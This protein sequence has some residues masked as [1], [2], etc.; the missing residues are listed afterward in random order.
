MDRV[1]DRSD[2]RSTSRIAAARERVSRAKVAIVVAAAVGFFSAVG[3]ERGPAVHRSNQSSQG[4]VSQSQDE[5]DDF[6]GS[7]S[8]TPTQQ[9]PSTST[10]SS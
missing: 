1:N 9:A 4:S 10:G 7:G 5:S 6:F 8:I 3:L 2:S